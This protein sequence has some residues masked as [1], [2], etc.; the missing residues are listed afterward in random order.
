MGTGQHAAQWRAGRGTLGVCGAA[1]L[2][3]D[4]FGALLYL[5]L[6]LWQAEFGL[7]LT[8][9]GLLKSAHS[10]VQAGLQTPVGLLAERLSERKLLAAGTAVTA[11]GFLL[12]GWAGGFAGLALF[13]V[14]AGAG[15]SVQHPLGSSLVSRAYERGA[16][17]AAIGIYNFSGDLGK[18]AVPAL[19]AVVI[20]GL[21]DWRWVTGG[22]AAIGLLAAAATVVAFGMFVGAPPAR[23]PAVAPRGARGARFGG[24][25]IRDRRG[26]QTLAAIGVIDNVTNTAFLTFLPFLLIAKGAAVG[27]VGLALTLIFAGGATGK[28]LCGFLAE[29]MGIVRTVMLTELCTGAG[30]LLILELP[31]TTAL[32]FMPALGVAL[33]G[34]SSVLLGT[35]AEFVDSERRARAFGLFYSLLF[36]ASALSPWLYGVVSDAVGVPVALRVVGVVALTTVPLSL[37]LRPA[38]RR[39]ALG[40]AD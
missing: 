37:L 13:L 5:V 11:L 2:L 6:P 7:S 28:F 27:T 30:I 36:A 16:R 22:A 25:G 12:L 40:A 21:G 26:F 23:R 4:G 34:T 31:L 32:V 24:W 15:S 14:I 8:Q 33:S 1:H 18:L 3:H 17:R 38:L 10:A 29:R 39:V 9:V 20:A 19:A 35:V